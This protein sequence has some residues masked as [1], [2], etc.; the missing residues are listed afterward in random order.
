MTSQPP[1]LRAEVAALAGLLAHAVGNIP[2]ARILENIARALRQQA[3][4]A[5][6]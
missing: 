2:A 5:M 6:Q 3:R 1:K 4:S